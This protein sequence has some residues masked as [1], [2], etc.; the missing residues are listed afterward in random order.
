[1]SDCFIV[2]QK[3][4]CMRV[5]DDRQEE[6]ESERASERERE[7]ERES[8]R[9]RKEDGDVPRASETTANSA[10]NLPKCLPVG[11]VTSCNR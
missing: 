2:W 5:R 11:R 7:R 1:M 6:S 4:S 3:V 9:E 10:R 8:A